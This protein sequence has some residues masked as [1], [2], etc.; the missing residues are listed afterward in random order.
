MSNDASPLNGHATGSGVDLA[1][2]G[3]LAQRLQLHDVA[4]QLVLGR[5]QARALGRRAA[6]GGVEPSRRRRARRLGGQAMHLLRHPA[7]L[8]E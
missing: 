4:G 8:P 7:A 5:P 3:A 1:L 6:R 2:L